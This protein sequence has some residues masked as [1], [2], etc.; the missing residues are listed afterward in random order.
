MFENMC[1]HVCAYMCMCVFAHEGQKTTSL[2]IFKPQFTS[3][4]TGSLIALK[5]P[6]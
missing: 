1:V 6:N 5:S 2:V 3:L 4:E